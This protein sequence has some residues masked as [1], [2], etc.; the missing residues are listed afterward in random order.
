MNDNS[1]YD[2]L[3]NEYLSLNNQ[4][5]SLISS[6]DKTTAEL[7][8]IEDM[9]IDLSNILCKYGKHIYEHFEENGKEQT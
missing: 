4:K 7:D 9:L 1:L 5:R 8:T 6:R 2:A 3:V